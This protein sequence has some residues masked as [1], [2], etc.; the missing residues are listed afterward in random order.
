[1]TGRSLQNG[2]SLRKKLG[3]IHTVSRL[4]PTFADLTDELLP[5][6]EVVV[7]VD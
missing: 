7:I 1:M 6:V 5:G 2:V 4:A 3:L